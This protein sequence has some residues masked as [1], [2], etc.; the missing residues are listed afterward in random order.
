VPPPAAEASEPSGGTLEQLVFG[1]QETGAID[2]AVA[3]FCRA[4]L[5]A[6]PAAVLF[7][8]ASVGA[9]FGL[10]LEDG[11]GVVV[12]V[13]QP[14]ERAE[15]LRA[16]QEV[17]APCTARASHARRPSRDPRPSAADSPWPRSSSTP[18]RSA[19]RTT[20]AAAG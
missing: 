3:A 5:G 13:H 17:Q 11:R 1:T 15:A 7:R 8:T 19:T 6:A 16:V 14:R 20:P 4:A 12:K 2:A 9:V 10:R 18:G